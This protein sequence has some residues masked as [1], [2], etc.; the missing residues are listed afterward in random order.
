LLLLLPFHLVLLV[1]PPGL[2]L[3]LLSPLPP[4][5]SLRARWRS[6]EIRSAAA[7]AV[8][9]HREYGGK[10]GSGGG[11]GREDTWPFLVYLTAR[12]NLHNTLACSGN[13]IC[14]SGRLNSISVTHPSHPPIIISLQAE[15]ANCSNTCRHVDMSRP[16]SPSPSLQIRPGPSPDPRRRRRRGEK[17]KGGRARSRRG[18]GGGELV[19]FFAG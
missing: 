9:S 13:L 12:N 11:G 18:S 14:R 16:P 15:I 8:H 5:H 7:A 19:N 3:S 1:L 2:S 17:E 10:D 4:L 6:L